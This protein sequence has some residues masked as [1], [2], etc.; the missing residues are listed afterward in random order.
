MLG[1]LQI[2]QDFRI[3][4]PEAADSLFII[5]DKMYQGI[6]EY[7]D[8]QNNWKQFLRLKSPSTGKF[9]YASDASVPLEMFK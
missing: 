6:W 7:A 9:N 5:W 2:E 1:W 4:L 3:I 8:K